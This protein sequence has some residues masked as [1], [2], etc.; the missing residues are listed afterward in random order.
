MSEQA[1]DPRYPIGKYAPQPFSA[2]QLKEW[3]NDIKNLPFLLEQALGDLDEQQLD[4]PY[5]EGGW[6]IRR[7]THH[8][9]DA[10][11]N[12]YT[13]FKLALTEDNP[14]VKPYDE[15][16]WAGL[17]DSDL[18]VSVSVNFLHAL[19]SRFYE[20]ARNMDRED[21]DRTIFHPAQQKQFTLWQQ[22]GMYAW[23]GRHHVAHIT[24][25]RGKNAW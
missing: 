7:L 15:N 2:E 3:L 19:H 21:W 18:P 1:T 23:H 11:T 10:H 17:K 8:I 9:A 5:R 25:A 20:L 22:L 14:T 6:S 4:T 24:T 16:L 12:A 13:R